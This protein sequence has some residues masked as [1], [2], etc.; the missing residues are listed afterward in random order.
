ME[1]IVETKHC[2]Q[3]NSSFEITDKDLEFYDKVSPKFNGV[4]YSIPS[5][6]FCPDCRQQRRLAWRNERKLYKRKCDATG[7]PMISMYSPDKTFKVYAQYFWWSDK[8]DAME[9]G[10]DFDFSKSF[11]KQFEELV[12]VVPH[13]SLINHFKSNENSDY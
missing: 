13:N 2:K 10:V 8:W 6:T 1:K 4:K 3:C 7:K 5:P 11:F 9:Y 12:K